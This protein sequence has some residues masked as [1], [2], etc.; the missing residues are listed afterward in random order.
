M[1]YRLFLQY[2]GPDIKNTTLREACTY[3]EKRGEITEWRD[4]LWVTEDRDAFWKAIFWSKQSKELNIKL[5]MRLSCIR[6]SKIEWK[7]FQNK[8][9]PMAR[10]QPEVPQL[11]E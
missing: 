7:R 1:T 6:K 9:I 10:L 5:H 11:P 3:I 8:V 4:Y 2:K